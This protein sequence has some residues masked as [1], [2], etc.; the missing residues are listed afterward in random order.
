MQIE[1]TLRRPGGFRRNV[2]GQVVV[3]Q[4]KV[5][6]Q[7]KLPKRNLSFWT[8]ACFIFSHYIVL[9]KL[10]KNRKIPNDNFRSISSQFP[11][12]MGKNNNLLALT[13]TEPPTSTSYYVR[14]RLLAWRPPSHH[15]A[16]R[17][18]ANQPIFKDKDILGLGLGRWVLLYIPISPGSS[19]G[20]CVSSTTNANGSL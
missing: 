2:I 6:G 12:P 9:H 16:L 1:V 17:W 15:L 3:S 8:F 10:T 7:K 11:R 4:N 14:S 20:L 18:R 19:L 5:R 13:P